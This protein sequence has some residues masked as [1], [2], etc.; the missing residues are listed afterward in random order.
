MFR[1]GRLMC[2]TILFLCWQVP[3]STVILS[4]VNLLSSS[5]WQH[6]RS[7]AVRTY[8]IEWW[9]VAEPFWETVARHA[10]TKV[11]LNQTSLIDPPHKYPTK[12]PVGIPPTGVLP[13]CKIMFPWIVHV[14]TFL[15]SRQELPTYSFLSFLHFFIS[16]LS[17]RC[18][19]SA[20]SFLS[21]L[22]FICF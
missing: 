13:D 17:H 4:N 18:G 10:A 6:Y 8:S 16:C 9:S 21:L 11:C 3:R 22:L 5:K 19:V 1:V 14:C 2:V 7:V 15:C 20:D 12:V